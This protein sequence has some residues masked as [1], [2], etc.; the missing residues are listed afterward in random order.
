MLYGIPT[1]GSDS[2]YALYILYIWVSE[3]S[4]PHGLSPSKSA[5]ACNG[6]YRQSR[7]FLEKQVLVSSPDVLSEVVTVHLGNSCLLTVPIFWK[8]SIHLIKLSSDWEQNRD[9]RRWNEVWNHVNLPIHCFSQT[10]CPQMRGEWHSTAVYS[11]IA[12]IKRHHFL[13]NIICKCKDEHCEVYWI[14]LATIG[15]ILRNEKQKCMLLLDNIKV[16]FY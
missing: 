9:V 15:Y 12:T 5:T 11:T 13:C 7:C 10:R 2:V 3:G 4:R 16:I 6:H 1:A 8:L 14:W